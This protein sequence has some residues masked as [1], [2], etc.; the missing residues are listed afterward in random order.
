VQSWHSQTWGDVRTGLWKCPS[1]AT[2]AMANGGGYGVLESI[3]GTWYL[4]DQPPLRRGQVTARPTRGLLADSEDVTAGV[5]R[6]WC[7]FW[8]S[9]EVPGRWDLPSTH[10]VAARHGRGR[11]ANVAYMDGHVAAAQYLDLASN[12]GDVWRYTTP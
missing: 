9:V 5:A 2:T 8:S 1:V 3:H 12:I 4:A 11:T 10:R 7:A 6:S